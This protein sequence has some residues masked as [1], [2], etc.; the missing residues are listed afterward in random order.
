LCAEAKAGQLVVSDTVRS[1]TRASLDVVFE[2]LGP[3]HLKGVGEPVACYRVVPYAAP[4]GVRSPAGGGRRTRLLALATGGVA[5][6]ALVAAGIAVLGGSQAPAPSPGPSMAAAA[7]QSPASTTPGPTSN[8]SPTGSPSASPTLGPFPNTV[9]SAML[10]ALPS[11]LAKTCVRGGTV[12]DARLAGFQGSIN[13]EN[14]DPIS[15]GRIVISLTPDSSGGLTCHPTSG[16]GRIYLMQPMSREGKGFGSEPN[17]AAGDVYLGYLAARYGLA[18][19]SCAT[20][21]QA[22]ESWSGPSGGG[23]LACM[24]PYEGRPWIYFTFGKGKYLAFATRDD[25]DY[26]DLYA[27]WE[28]IRTFLP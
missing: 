18:Q 25:T 26:A 23:Q 7:T 24:N 22:Q 21:G 14:H 27:W 2:S 15:P 6:V 16:A 5:V 11:T 1:L 12:A 19:G 3:R 28:Q 4:A 13:V 10:A 9:E 17:F 8:G 20:V